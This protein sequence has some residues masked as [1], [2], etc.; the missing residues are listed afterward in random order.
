MPFAV[1][2]FYS[3][4]LF[5]GVLP[6]QRIPRRA[7]LPSKYKIERRPTM[8]EQSFKKVVEKMSDLQAKHAL[9]YL[10]IQLDDGEMPSILNLIALFDQE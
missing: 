7:K 2:Y 8:K 9:L 5:R 3:P 1:D 4:S 6:S 10:A